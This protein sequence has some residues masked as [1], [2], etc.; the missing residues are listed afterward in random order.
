[1]TIKNVKGNKKTSHIEKNEMK[2]LI[3]ILER[4]DDKMVI[5]IMGLLS[6]EVVPTH[7]PIYLF[8]INHI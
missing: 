3:I 7:I 5:R 4:N 6:A 2:E 1:M 8:C